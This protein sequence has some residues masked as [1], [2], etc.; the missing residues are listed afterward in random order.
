MLD[1]MQEYLELLSQ[2]GGQFVACE[3]LPDYLVVLH[4]LLAVV[5]STLQ[6]ILVRRQMRATPAG[7]TSL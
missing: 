7:T 1:D 4:Q 2:L 3:L 5:S 6:T